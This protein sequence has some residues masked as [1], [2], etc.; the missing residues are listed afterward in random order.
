MELDFP[1]H[2]LIYYINTKFD[3][4]A[5]RRQLHRRQAAETRAAAT[6][7]P[8]RTGYDSGGA[9][10]GYGG[11][12]LPWSLLQETGGSAWETKPSSFLDIQEVAASKGLN[13]NTAL[14]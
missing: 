12:M 3:V 10:Q 2:T 4:S 5:P 8:S 1:L 11:R 9:T 13:V 7:L 6:S 14:T